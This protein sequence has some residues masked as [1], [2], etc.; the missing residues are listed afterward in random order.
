MNNLP[1]IIA[2]INELLEAAHEANDQDIGEVVQASQMSELLLN[3][4]TYTKAA[5][6]FINGLEDSTSID[7]LLNKRC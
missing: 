2:A 7:R 1:R 5:S 4:Q 6:R 3:A